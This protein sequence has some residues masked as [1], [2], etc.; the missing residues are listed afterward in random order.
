MLTRKSRLRLVLVGLAVAIFFS[1]A[2]LPGCI[3][4]NAEVDEPFE[5]TRNSSKNSRVNLPTQ[6]YA[7][8]NFTG[9]DVGAH[10]EVN[11]D[12]GEQHSVS[13]AAQPGTRE[14]LVVEVRKGV[15]NLG[16]SKRVRNPGDVI[17]D[18]VMPALDYLGV[19][20][21][22][23]VEVMRGF[24]AEQLRLDGSGAVNI[25]IDINANTI[26]TDLSGASDLDIAGRTLRIS[27][28]IPRERLT[29]IVR[30]FRTAVFKP[31]RTQGRWS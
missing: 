14:L 13:I 3:Y 11:I 21:A 29:W 16:F 15:L 7:V 18:I 20:G 23:D 30:F 19:S 12:P 10:F 6:Q 25:E 5:L 24:S 4:V 8:T 28:S 2:S 22:A 26:I 9:V 17:V 1:V 27:V 31:G